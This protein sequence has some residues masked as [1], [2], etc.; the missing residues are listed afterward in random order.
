M[1]CSGWWCHLLRQAHLVCIRELTCHDLEAYSVFRRQLWPYH[2]GAGYWEVV[3]TKYFQNPHRPLCPG[4]GL[5][6]YFRE[7]RLLGMMGAYPMPVTL[8]GIIHPGHMLVDW[9]VL[10]SFRFGPVAGC[11]WNKLVALPGLK[12]GS[13]GSTFSQKPL[14]KRGTKIHSIEGAAMLSPIS[15]VAVRLLEPKR[16][17]LASPLHLDLLETVPGVSLFEGAKVRTA[18]PGKQPNTAHVQ[19]DADFWELY[20][21]ARIHTGAFP[22]KV[23][24]TE[25][26]A[27]VIVRITEE[28]KFRFG[29]LLSAYLSPYSIACA[30]ETGRLLRK[31]LH[32]LRVSVLYGTEADAELRHLL[33]SVGSVVHRS[34]VY[35]WSIPT[36]CDRFRKNEVSWW[37]TSAD[38]DSIYG[39]QQVF[40]ER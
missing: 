34:P 2:S 32:R 9:A 27:D 14:E 33:K 10:P 4:S 8:N 36:P 19:R 37:L 30:R 1:S 38:R 40:A 17:S 24:S 39:G 5:Y 6:G 28:G 29:M 7:D 13:V 12:F 23:T 35:W 25:G 11:L 18:V 21:A 20:C 31:F 15:G 22:L 26:E 16:Y 3:Q